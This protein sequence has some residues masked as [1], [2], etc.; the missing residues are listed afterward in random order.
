MNKVVRLEII[1][2]V[3]LTWK[4]FGDILYTLRAETRMAKNKTLFMRHEWTY[5]QIDYHNQYNKWPKCID[6][7]APYKILSAYCYDKLKREATYLNT[8]N[9]VA[10]IR[11]AISKYDAHK[12]DIMSGKVSVPS[13]GKGQPIDLHNNNIRLI[14]NRNN[15]YSAIL[16]L[17]SKSGVKAF[18]L[19]K[20]Q[21][22][23]ALKVRD[24]SSRTIINRCI[25]G[26][27]KIC[28]SQIVHDAQKK[29]DYLN[30]CYAFESEKKELDDNRCMG[31]D[32]GVKLPVVMAFSNDERKCVK[33]D[34]NRIMMQKGHLDHMLSI[35]KHHSQ[36]TSTGN[37]GHGRAKKVRCYDRY[38]GRSAK[39]SDTINHTWAKFVVENAVK[40]QCGIIQMEDLSGIKVGRER[41]L[42]NWTYYDLQM[43][44]EQKAQMY[45]VKVV[46]INPEYTSQRCSW[47][48]HI[49]TENRK[50]QAD[51]ECKCCKKSANAD[52]NAARNIAT[53]GIEEIIKKSKG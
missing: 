50:T 13:M 37:S 9:L 2:P 28:G 27:Y 53:L 40:N 20:G 31:I 41:F 29:K 12:K 47:C 24:A 4:E 46:K 33:I 7:H 44:I 1:K 23:V 48:G 22:E 18:N 21:I 14:D 16:S 19:E 36:W 17:L 3:I 52:W 39:L 10:S 30:L 34:D 51:F 26:E 38:S 35:A 32:L 49:S 8:Q 42:K 6:L 5:E 25:S 11:D 15:N 43:K 45:G